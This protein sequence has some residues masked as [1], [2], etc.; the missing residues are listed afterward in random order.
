MLDANN[1][2]AILTTFHRLEQAWNASLMIEPDTVKDEDCRHK[3]QEAM[4]TLASAFMEFSTLTEQYQLD[5]DKF[6]E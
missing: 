2:L 3:L 4:E 5:L 1:K 6:D